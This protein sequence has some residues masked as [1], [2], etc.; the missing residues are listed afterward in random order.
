[1]SDLI[2]IKELEEKVF[3]RAVD[4]GLWDIF[5]GCF[6]LMFAIAPLLSRRMGDFLSSAIFIPVW[7]GA[8]FLIWLTRRRVVKPRVGRVEFGRT[9]GLRLERLGIIMLY[10]NAVVFFIGTMAAVGVFGIAGPL[11]SILFGLM[12]LMMFSTAA[13]FLKFSRL[14]LYGLLGAISPLAGEVLYK[15]ASVPHHGFPITFGITSAIMMMVGTCI[16]VNLLRHHPVI[17]EVPDREAL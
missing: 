5:L 10:A 4:D 12:L 9:R 17:E 1:M 8:Y 14:Y 16:F 3:R 11:Y 7:G 13:Y 15:Y 6:F 2:S